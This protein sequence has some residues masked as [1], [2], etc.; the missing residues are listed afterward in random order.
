[1]RR[2]PACRRARGQRSDGFTAKTQ[3]R[4]GRMTDMLQQKQTEAEQA[5]RAADVRVSNQEL[6]EAITAI[7][8]RRSDPAFADTITLGDAVRQLSLDVS[9]EQ[10]LAEIEAKRAAVVVQPVRR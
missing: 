1:M 7:E 5:G 9:P 10:I 3:T 2:R 4:E 8:A 6:V